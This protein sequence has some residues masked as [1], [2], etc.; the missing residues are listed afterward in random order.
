MRTLLLSAALLGLATTASAQGTLTGIVA[1]AASGETLVG[2]NVFIA[3][4]GRGAATDLDGEYR[5]TGLPAGTYS[6]RY[7]FAGLEVQNV[8][9]IEIRDGETTTINVQLTSGELEVVEITAEA[10]LE[11]NTEV[12]LLR[13]RQRA[14]A[15]S[16][17]ISAETISESGG[18]DAADAMERV[19]GA[20]VIGGKYVAIRGLSDRYANTQ[21][22]GAQLPTADPDRRS[23]QFD[24]FPA[25]LL[26]NITTLKTFTPDQP[27][28]FSGGLVDIATKSFPGAF[29][30]RMSA[31]GG[32][33]SQAQVGGDFLASTGQ[34]FGA[35]GVSD[36]PALPEIVADPEIVI[37]D[38]RDAR[39]GGPEA[40]QLDAISR[41]F[42]AP[43]GVGEATAPVNQS[44]ALSLGNEQP[45]AGG[46]LGYVISGN[47]NRSASGYAEGETGRYTATAQGSGE[48]RRLFLDPELLLSDASGAQ[49]VAYGGIGN[50]AFRPNGTNEVS[51]NTLFTR[52]E[53]ATARFQV[54]TLPEIFDEPGD[55][56]INR[57]T[58]YIQR[59]LASAQLRGR[60]Q[61]GGAELT[62]L[63]TA[64]QTSLDEPDLRFFGN[65]RTGE[66]GDYRYSTQ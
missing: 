20:S 32:V 7:S 54:G 26:D 14:A 31:S 8:T 16:D 58:F 12:G 10:I 48:D 38:F 52:S 40:E 27:G 53:E 63:G 25:N 2:A 41:A 18:S 47:Y 11:L 21:L 30:L 66:P 36:A 50:I 42:I 34:S 55:L 60:H 28:N 57:S 5:I 23:V 39:R 64:S 65:T 29:S 46:T 51:L 49:E 13:Q 44:Y 59:E 19:T 43:I 17:A 33:N 6:V 61:V 3:D 24:L 15:V 56:F 35:F 62:W 4:L 37:P 22:N 45:L 9:G 1:D